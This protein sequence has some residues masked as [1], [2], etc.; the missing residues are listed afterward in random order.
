MKNYQNQAAALQEGVSQEIE[1]TEQ[2]LQRYEFRRN[3][4]NKKIEYREQRDGTDLEPAGF[5]PDGLQ[6]YLPVEP[7]F[8]PLTDAAMNTI[9][10]TAKKMLPEMAHART[11]I[12]EYVFS[13]EVPEYDP[14]RDW[15]DHLPAWDGTDY[16][17]ELYSRLPGISEEAVE[18]LKT[19]H[20]SMVAHWLQMDTLHANES[21]PVLI[22]PQGCGKTI[23]CRRL[24]PKHLQEY[25]LD[26]FNMGNKFDRDLALSN[27]GLVIIDE[28]D[29]ITSTQQANLKFAISR[30]K[31]NGRPIFGRVQE[32]NPRYASF[33][34]TTNCQ[35]PLHDPTGSRRYICVSIPEGQLIDNEVAIDYEQLYAQVLHAL[36]EEKRRYWFTNAEEQRI[37]QVNEQFQDEID[38]AP[39]VQALYRL[40]KDD[41]SSQP[42][43]LDDIASTIGSRYPAVKCIQN[44]SIYLGR[45]L[46]K[47]GFK[48][49]RKASG[50]HY[51]AIPRQAAA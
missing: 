16:L 51:Y 14:F 6:L 5:T 28:F 10:R 18:W 33:I 48:S 46:R 4:F 47:L 37:Q 39:L 25:V 3:T 41:E 44:L 35:H 12:E 15:L 7:R 1:L 36:R 29:R 43:A 24:L 20:L 13:T 21:V 23:F 2:F 19:W 40:P 9:V 8:Q 50:A 34:A 22:G 45:I 49:Q 38:L 27:N 42:I 17:R 11:N 32:D 30:N 26:H 31:V